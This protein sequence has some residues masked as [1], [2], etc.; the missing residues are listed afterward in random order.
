MTGTLVNTGAIVAGGLIGMS[1]GRRLPER[2]KTIM[3][4][5]LGLSVV[6]VGIQMALAVTDLIVTIGCMLVGAITGELIR[7]E[8][9]VERLGEWLKARTR[10]SS[11]TFSEGFM[12]ASVLYLTGA[13][14]I[15]GS[16]QDG[17]IGDPT[18]LYVKA[19]LDGV[20]AIPLASSL[21]IGVAFSALSVFAVQGSLTLLA[22][23]L[24]F[25]QDP[26]VLN[27]VTATGGL[28]IIGIGLN[29]LNVTKIPIGNFLP[30]ILYAIV[31]AVFM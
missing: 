21:G 5:A 2:I 15:V 4:Q 28:L 3:V 19:L 13:M 8:Y 12:S 6:L 9:W 17:T 31:W 11:S 22:S 20:I 29:L 27:A 25:M 23:H 1:V 24:L 16:I 14:M 30:A 18:T 10:S 7:I 26:A